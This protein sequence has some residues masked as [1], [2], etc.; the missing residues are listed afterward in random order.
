M[1]VFELS[2]NWFDYSFNNPDKIKPIHTAIYFF[3]IERSNRMGWKEKFGLPT[4]MAM[5]ALGVKSYNTYSKALADIVQFGFVEMIEKSK[6]QYTA[7]IIALSKF[8]KAHDK[9]DTKALDKALL[10][11]DSKQEKSTVQSIDSIDIHNNLTTNKHKYINTKK[12]EKEISKSKKTRIESVLNLDKD[13]KEVFDEWLEY[14]N[15][16]KKAIKNEKTLE[17]LS[18][19]FNKYSISKCKKVIENSI[20]NRWQGLFWD[21]VKDDIN[22]EEKVVTNESVITFCDNVNPTKRKLPKSEFLKL[23]KRGKE[24][25]YVYKIIS[26]ENA[27]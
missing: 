14:R 7:N 18:K 9:A 10:K 3:I 8:D 16:I 2:R 27:A 5:E 21:K 24:G 13:R 12:E 11:H 22:C 20:E 4:D 23:Q 15:E 1:N 19:K 25:G 6:N 26:E 17:A